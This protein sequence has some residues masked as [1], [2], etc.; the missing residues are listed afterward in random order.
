MYNNFTLLFSHF[1]ASIWALNRRR[2][3]P[4]KLDRKTVLTLNTSQ[5]YLIFLLSCFRARMSGS[6]M[7]I[8]RT[9]GAQVK[10]SPSVLL[11][12]PISYCARMVFLR[13]GHMTDRRYPRKAMGSR[14]SKK[15]IGGSLPCKTSRLVG[16]TTPRVDTG[17]REE[18]MDEVAWHWT[19]APLNEH[20]ECYNI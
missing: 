16:H 5:Q 7:T 19:V 14:M 6:V 3:D 20:L 15:R 10:Q 18:V 12:L 13:R 4:H 11:L 2:G 1:Q 17:C 8:S 9:Q